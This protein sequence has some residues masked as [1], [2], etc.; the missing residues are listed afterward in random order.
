LIWA[1]IFYLYRSSDFAMNEPSSREKRTLKKRM[2]SFGFAWNGI[3]LMFATQPNAVIHFIAMVLVV[4]LGFFFQISLTEWAL[5]VFAIGLVLS[6]EA[7]NTALENLVD[8]ASPEYNE[9][10]GR[11]K[12]IAAGAV[13]LAAICAVI[14]GL[15][16]FLP[17]FILFLNP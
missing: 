15:I 12:D 17:K 8:L 9:R 2:R 5:V 16:I 6:A 1:N 4:V 7:F 11:V 14:I 13:L 3:R 10:A